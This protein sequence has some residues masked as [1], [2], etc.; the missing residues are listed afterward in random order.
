M[1]IDFSKKPTT[2]VV[3]TLAP[4]KRSSSSS[5]PPA[6]P[7][8]A[9][10][11]RPKLPAP[12]SRLPQNTTRSV[13]SPAR[14]NAPAASL[15][16]DGKRRTLTKRKAPTPATPMSWGDSSEGSEDE[17]LTPRKR[18]RGSD[19]LEPDVMRRIRLKDSGDDAPMALRFLHGA[20][21]VTREDWKDKDVS[22]FD[23]KKDFK[24][25]FEGLDEIPTVELQYP[26]RAQRERFSLVYPRDNEG[27]KPLEDIIQ[28]VETICKYYFP[29]EAEEL[30]DDGTG[31][32]RRL[33][34]A[35]QQQSFTSFKDV[36]EE[37]NRL[38]YDALTSG[39][40]NRAIDEMQSMP[41]PLTEY[42]L[43]QTY[44]RTVSPRVSS[45]RRYEAGS[46][47]VYGELLPRFVHRIFQETRLKSDQVFVDLGSGVGNVALQAALEVGCESWG[48]ESM[49]NPSHCAALQKREIAQRARLWN[50][51]I[52]KIHL[53]ADDFLDNAEIGPVLNRADVII[54]NNKAFS[55]KLNGALLDRFLDL[56]EGAKIVSLK[57]FVDPDHEIKSFN[58]NDRVNLFR[59]VEREYFSDSV[60]WTNEGGKY[61]IQ[62]KDR[63]RLDDFLASSRRR[64]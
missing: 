38:V 27:Y 22:G 47:N 59:S 40:T 61:Y 18:V 54:V 46:N 52:G 11:P 32:P 42:I 63:S 55:P 5:N 57:P 23:L 19:S 25:A 51:S 28:S 6:S 64:K 50:I 13:S 17:R 12:S 39:K 58:I 1:N 26:S 35:I 34:R 45:L 41:L 36:L 21:L 9:S 14:R 7:Q 56:K 10:R 48:I 60:S 20:D 24:P 2:R 3:K 53:L 29:H 49:P 43:S 30:L 31:F 15:S 33:K 62:T 44:A 8:P 16:T 37:F 4:V